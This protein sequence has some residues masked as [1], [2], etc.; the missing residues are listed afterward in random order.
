MIRLRPSGVD[1][2]LIK[3]VRDWYEPGPGV[4]FTG[5]TGTESFSPAMLFT[6]GVNGAWYDPS[7]LT[8]LYQDAAGTIPVTAFEQPVGRMLDKS[9][10]GNHA[11]NPSG[12]SANFPVLSARYNLLTKSEQFADAYWAKNNATVTNPTATTIVETTAANSE[13]NI[14]AAIDSAAA[15]TYTFSVECAL[16]SGTRYA[17]IQIATNNA[18]NST[19][20]YTVVVDLS[21]GA[22][23][24]EASGAGTTGKSK[25]VTSNGSGKW[26]ISVSAAHSSGT[27]YGVIGMSNSATP[28]YNAS[29]NP[30]YTGDGTSGIYIWGADLRVSNDALNQPAYQRVNTA[31][32]YDTVGF[33]PYP[34]FNGTNQ[35]LQTSSIDFSYG[36][37]MFVSAGV[38]KLS[39]AGNPIIIELSSADTNSWIFSLFAGAPFYSQEYR[40]A[41]RGTSASAAGE[42]VNV[43]PSTNI[44]SGVGDISGDQAILRVNGTQVATSTADQGTGNYG[45]YPLYIGARAGTSLWFNGRLYGLVVAGK[46]ASA[47]EITNTEAFTNQK[48]GAY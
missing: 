13:H 30:T 28:T 18:D 26:R 8:T 4:F 14:F 36:D 11:F 32:D 9:G 42:T 43:P 39:D 37:K 2:L 45:N 29:S 15:A 24:S 22:V 48:T 17:A 27:V 5:I 31:S 3:R 44:V 16:S 34:R 38:R 21:D 1:E 41:S 33:K 12:N 7:D 20:R 23:K 47:S 6:T 25:S 46:A 40:F 10:R 35:W 19:G